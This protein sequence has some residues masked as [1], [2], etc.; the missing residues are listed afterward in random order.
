M[1]KRSN[2]VLTDR[3]IPRM[4]YWV[5]FPDDDKMIILT[6]EFISMLLYFWQT[7]QTQSEQRNPLPPQPVEK[8]CPFL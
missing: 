2:F 5:L 8:I 4:P 3:K 1:K 7:G 6:M